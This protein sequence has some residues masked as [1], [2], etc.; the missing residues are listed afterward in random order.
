[1]KKPLFNKPLYNLCRLITPVLILA[2]VVAR[3]AGY[4]TIS[5]CLLIVMLVLCV[6]AMLVRNRQA[7]F[8]GVETAYGERV[9]K[10]FVDRDQQKYRGKLVDA[11][12]L[13]DKKEQH[14]KAADRLEALLKHCR[15]DADYAFVQMLLGDCYRGLA[16]FTEAECFYRDSLS[17]DDTYG[18]VWSNLGSIC[19][20][21]E[22]H[23][24]AIECHL[25]AVKYDDKYAVGFNNLATAY[26]RC[27]QYE[28]CIEP[29]LQALRLMPRYL[30]PASTLCLAYYQLGNKDKSD[31]YY[32][33]INSLGGNEKA[34]DPLRA[35]ID[36][37]RAEKAAPPA[38]S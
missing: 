1:M 37:E 17:H 11:I 13:L 2:A 14:R 28:K 27:G 4:D 15:T 33:M 26:Y 10:V 36:K 9:Q 31:E 38:Q 25:N 23:E 21:L 29:C 7:R 24:E 19:S 6:P 5:R 16:N 34:L 12:Y 20:K 3:G 18:M 22:R 8:H 30:S 32:R 35:E